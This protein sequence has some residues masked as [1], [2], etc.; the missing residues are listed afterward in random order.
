MLGDRCS[1]TRVAYGYFSF[2]LS[3]NHIYHS[4]QGVTLAHR[5][6]AIPT[7]PQGLTAQLGHGSGVNT[8]LFCRL[9]QREAIGSH[10]RNHPESVVPVRLELGRSTKEI[11]G[12]AGWAKYLDV[13]SSLGF[14]SY[15]AACLVLHVLMFENGGRKYNYFVLA[16]FRQIQSCI[17]AESERRDEASA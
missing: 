7:F 8:L 2:S 3:C 15:C 6:A 12:R 9:L 11:V 13:R 16:E 10:L 1:L 14:S 17:L 4:E 5:I